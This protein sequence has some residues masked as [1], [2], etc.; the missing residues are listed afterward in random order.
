MLRNLFHVPI[1]IFE[2]KLTN[3]EIEYWC[4]YQNIFGKWKNR[5]KYNMFGV[6]YY[7][8]FFIHSKMRMNLIMVRKKKER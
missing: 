8:V 1:R 5:I 3:G 2:R 6:S 7:A 4:Q